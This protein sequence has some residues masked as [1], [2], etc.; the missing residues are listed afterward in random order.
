MIP[1]VGIDIRHVVIPHV[2]EQR[3]NILISSH[4]RNKKKTVTLASM[5]FLVD[6]K[7]EKQEEGG[8]KKS[9]SSLPSLSGLNCNQSLG[10]ALKCGTSLRVFVF[11][12]LDND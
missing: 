10:G 6:E 4:P 11:L 5:R 12:Q 2:P 1:E 8:R 9:K 7:K 3:N